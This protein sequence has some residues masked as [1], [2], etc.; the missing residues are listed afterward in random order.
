MNLAML[1]AA[2]IPAVFAILD[3]MS[4]QL[5]RY[6]QVAAGMQWAEGPPKLQGL[7]VMSHPSGRSVE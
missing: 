2:L 5:A 3:V 7:F 4:V 1:I 6:Q